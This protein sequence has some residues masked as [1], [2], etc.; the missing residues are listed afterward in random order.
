MATSQVR[1]LNLQTGRRVVVVDHKNRPRW[2]DAFENNPRISRLHQHDTVSLLNA[3]GSRPYIEQ[4]TA[5]RW[6]WKKWDIQPGEVFLSDVEKDFAASFAGRILVEPNT[7]IPDG[8]K[9][10][11]FER[12]Q[13]LVRRM[14]PEQFIQ[15]GPPGARRLDGVRFSQTTFRLAL[16][17]LSVSR[18]FVGTEG[19]LHHAAAALGVPAVVLWSEFISP[20][21]T[22]YDS[23]IN[24]R[25]AGVACGNRTRC[26][27]CE[28]AM[29][30]IE[31]DE[32]QLSLEKLL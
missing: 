8:N 3:G 22:G 9:A 25:H 16:A 7:K 30:A 5:V 6:T 14:G 2:S 29:S 18:A 28:A 13:E 23:Q 24:I 11:K 1:S 10:W 32:V 21:F 15:V 20:E 26:V 27:G 12:W 17:V 19:A 4:K 31:V